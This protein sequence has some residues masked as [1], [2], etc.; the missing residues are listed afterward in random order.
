MIKFVAVIENMKYSLS[1]KWSK[2]LK[3]MFSIFVQFG[4]KASCCLLCVFCNRYGLFIYN[5]SLFTNM[6]IIIGILIIMCPLM[7]LISTFG[8]NNNIQFKNRFYNY[9]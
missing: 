6:Y 9:C 2:Y 5:Y 4:L 7:I 1:S 3:I 8:N